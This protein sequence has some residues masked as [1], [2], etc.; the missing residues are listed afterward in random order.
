MP[1]AARRSS[2]SGVVASAHVLA[3]EAGGRI[4]AD[5]GNA[6]DAAVAVAACL[7]V[8]E[9]FMSGLA[10]MGYATMWVAAEQRVRVL[11]FVQPVPRSFPVQRFSKREQLARG[12]HSVGPPGNLAGWAE[13]SRTYGGLPLARVFEPAIALAADGFPIGRFGAEQITEHA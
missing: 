11:D 8:V 7:N 13:L 1:D 9:P 6:F 12:P 3:S 4:L 5:G 10:G 2:T